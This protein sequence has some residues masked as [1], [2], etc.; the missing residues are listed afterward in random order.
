M[1]LAALIAALSVM[2][3]RSPVP[4]AAQEGTPAMT[5][6]CVV[7]TSTPGA[8][9][10]EMPMAGTP[11]AGMDHMVMEFDQMYIDMMIPHHQSIIAMAQAALPRLQDDPLRE[12]AQAVIEEQGAEIEQLQ[13]YR[14]AWYGDPNPMPMDEAMMAA[15]VE[16]MPGMGD[17][18]SMATMMDAEAL[19]AAFCAA[20]NS[21]LSFID[22][23]IPHHEMAIQASEAAMERAAHD[24]IR[25]VAERVI[26]DQ[27][28]EIDELTAIRQEFTEAATP[29]A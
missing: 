9:A 4:T 8:M 2:V 11:A 23:T 6:A 15:M 16:M 1:F 28:R 13:E 17:S 25:M 19:V 29:S 3:P 27:Q 7:G 21:D 18:E 26:Q 20:E 5:Y 10:H 14:E 22:L 24:E 12:I